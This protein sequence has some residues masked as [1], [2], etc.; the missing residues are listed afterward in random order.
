[1][2]RTTSDAVPLAALAAVMLATLV[3]VV[4][5]RRSL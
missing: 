5:A 2:S 3:A 1:V 4:L